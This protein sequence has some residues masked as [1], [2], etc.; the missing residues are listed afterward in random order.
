MIILNR[1]NNCSNSTECSKVKLELDYIK[2]NYGFFPD[3]IITFEKSSAKLLDQITLMKNTVKKLNQVEDETG[4]IISGKM[5]NIQ[6]KN[7]GYDK[8]CIDLITDLISR[9]KDSFDE[10]TELENNVT[11]D[12][13]FLLFQLT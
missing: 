5:K 13:M 3:C 7:Y 2:P 11:Q 8:L 9:E 10:L 12:F 1:N 4:K 6:E